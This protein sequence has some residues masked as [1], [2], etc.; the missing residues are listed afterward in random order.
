MPIFDNQCEKKFKIYLANDE[1]KM[2]KVRESTKAV[3]LVPDDS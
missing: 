1:H 3:W 2:L